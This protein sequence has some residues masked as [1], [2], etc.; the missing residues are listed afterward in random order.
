[1]SLE[2]FETNQQVQ[3]SVEDHLNAYQET[4]AEIETEVYNEQYDKSDILAKLA[5]EKVSNHQLNNLLKTDT[6][7]AR[8]ISNFFS[9]FKR[10]Q[11]LKQTVQGDICGNVI[12]NFDYLLGPDIIGQAF[13]EEEEDGPIHL[14]I[15]DDLKQQSLPNKDFLL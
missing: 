5:D 6:V 10:K 9:L 7:D 1:M 14:A 11:K 3:L 4:L 2:Q 8:N 15:L 12:S 13:K